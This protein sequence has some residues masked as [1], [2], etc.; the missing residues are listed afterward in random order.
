MPKTRI[1]EAEL[2]FFFFFFQQQLYA[3]SGI[4]MFTVQGECA[5]TQNVI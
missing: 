3:E 5:S 2:G 4:K 1:S